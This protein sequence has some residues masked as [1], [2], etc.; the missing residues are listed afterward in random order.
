[1]QRIVLV[2]FSIPSRAVHEQVA[3][4]A[5]HDLMSFL[6]PASL[7]VSHVGSSKS[8][9]MFIAQ[10]KHEAVVHTAVCFSPKL[11]GFSIRIHGALVTLWRL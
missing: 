3:L 11:S 8:R 9:I 4:K 10:A 5:Q 6:Q 2:I 1:M 7:L